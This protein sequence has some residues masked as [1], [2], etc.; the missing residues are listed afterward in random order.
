MKV[1]K[2]EMSLFLMGVK[3]VARSVVLLIVLV[4]GLYFVANSI[5]N[6]TG[7]FVS[8]LNTEFESCLGNRDIILYVDNYNMMELKKLKTADYLGNIEVSGCILNK[9]DCAKNGIVEYP[10]WIIEGQKVVGDID[11]FELADYANCDMV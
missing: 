9:F 5:T 3:K 1:F 10:T 11:I 2:C 7:Y 4:V 8:E 6:F